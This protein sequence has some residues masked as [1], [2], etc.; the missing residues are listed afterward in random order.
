MH[1][2]AT[3]GAVRA[4]PR[5]RAR[6]A[7]GRMRRRRG[8]E[9]VFPGFETPRKPSSRR[10]TLVVATL[11]VVAGRG[12]NGHAE[13]RIGRDEHLDDD[14]TVVTYMGCRHEDDGLESD[15]GV[16]PSSPLVAIVPPG[17]HYAVWRTTMNGYESPRFLFGNNG[18]VFEFRM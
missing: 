9:V 10:P 6:S 11:A 16:G 8:P 17:W 12:E 14:S 15:A 2:G 7:I 13:L 4:A 5:V 18:G 1:V 3:S